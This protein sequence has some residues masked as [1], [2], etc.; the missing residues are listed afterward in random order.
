LHARNGSESAENEESAFEGG[1]G[2]EVE[3]EVVAVNHV[4]DRVV[5]GQV[6]PFDFFVQSDLRGEDLHAKDK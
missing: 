2:A 1:R 3:G 6:H 5:G 4:L